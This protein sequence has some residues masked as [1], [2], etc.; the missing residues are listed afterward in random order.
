ML[1]VLDTNHPV[2]REF[3]FIQM[4]DPS[5]IGDNTKRKKNTENF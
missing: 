5:P 4:K 1:T 3:N 2:G